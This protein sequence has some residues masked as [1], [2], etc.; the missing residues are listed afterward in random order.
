MSAFIAKPLFRSGL[1]YGLR[2]L[3]EAKAQQEQEAETDLAGRRLL[4]AEDN[5]L[6]WE[7]ANDLLCECGLEVERAENGQIC[8][9]KFE[10]SAPGWYDGI[11]MDLRMPVMTGFEAA[12]TI[13]ASARKDARTIPIIAVSADAFAEDVQKCLDCGMNAHTAKP[14][15]PQVI[16]SLLRQ[17]LRRD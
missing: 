13:R 14:L 6:N 2:P 5:E 15:D 16:L 7:I 9:E 12:A 1:Y 4:L 3:I 10:A 11:L 8:V 17:Y